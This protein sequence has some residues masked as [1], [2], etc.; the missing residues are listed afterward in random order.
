MPGKFTNKKVLIPIIIGMVV[1]ITGLVVLI[2]FLNKDDEPE[3]KSEI[4]SDEGDNAGQNN[5]DIT[6]SVTDNNTQNN[7]SEDISSSESTGIETTDN[8]NTSEEKNETVPVT[9]ILG[10]YK[11]LEAKYEPETIT[12]EVIDNALERLKEEFTEIVE[13]PNRAFEDGDMAIVT[14]TGEIDGYKI[15][16]LSGVCLQVVIGEGIM[17][18]VIEKDII[19]RR[20]GD[21][22]Y[23][24]IDYPENFA[25]VPEVSGKTVNFTFE[26]VDG[27]EF[28]VPDI[29]DAFISEN[30]DYKTVDEYRTKE[31]ERLQKEADDEAREEMIQD[32]KNQVV[33]GCE[34]SGPI[35]DEIKVDYVRNLQEENNYFTENFY[36]DAATYYG[37]VYGLTVEEYRNT[38]MEEATFHI[39]YDYAVKEIMKLENLSSEEEVEKLI[40]DTCQIIE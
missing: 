38:K 21:T 18:E 15:D 30:T 20:I 34:F 14:F 22:F 35:D 7:G 4:I 25:E 27:F 24:D 6:G 26:L 16:D 37:L 29:T 28:I 5:N 11:G 36:M 39:K 12:D 19:G 9:V 32:L 3:P 33:D 13:L 8:N 40:T 31:K 2:I 23:Q 1:V 10:K 17:P